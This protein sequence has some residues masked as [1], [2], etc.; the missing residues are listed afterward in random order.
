MATE[1]VCTKCQVSVQNMRLQSRSHF[2]VRVQ[3]SKL[4]CN[5]ER[6]LARRMLGNVVCTHENRRLVISPNTV[7]FTGRN[8]MEPVSS[9]FD[10]SVTSWEVLQF[11]KGTVRVILNVEGGLTERDSVWLR[12]CWN[13]WA[14]SLEWI[15]FTQEHPPTTN[16]GKNAHTFELPLLSHP[17][18]DQGQNEPNQ[19]TILPS[20]CLSDSSLRHLLYVTFSS[21]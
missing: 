14:S 8:R 1:P 7:V 9:S 21:C 10:T 17:A 20:S 11:K 4:L 5:K 13:H 3:I 19:T 15:T 2:C 16:T 18:P 6:T 12:L